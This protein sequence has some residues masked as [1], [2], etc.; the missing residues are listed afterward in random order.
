M[1]HD[2]I[3]SVKLEKDSTYLE[4]SIRESRAQLFSFG[5]SHRHIPG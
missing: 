5:P 4:L 2:S 3:S 1:Y